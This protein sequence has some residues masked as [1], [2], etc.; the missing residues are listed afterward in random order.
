MKKIIN[1]LK[2]LLS[3]QSNP[4]NRII[5]IILTV[6]TLVFATL[7][8]LSYRSFYNQDGDLDK[9]VASQQ[10]INETESLLNTL[11]RTESNWVTYTYNPDKD[12]TV[13]QSINDK[14]DTI[15]ILSLSD[16]YQIANVNT[17]AQLVS[18]RWEKF[19]KPSAQ[20]R[21]PDSVYIDKV[22]RTVQQFKELETLKLQNYH[23]AA[24]QQ[25]RYSFYLN[26]GSVVIALMFGVLS[27][28]IFFRDREERKKV[29]SNLT[30]LN[31]NKD[32]FFSIIS[33]DLRG[34]TSNIVRLSEFLLEPN[35][36]ETDRKTMTLHLH[37][38][39]QNLQKLLENLLSWAKFQMGRL[40]FMPA[41]VDLYNLTNES[42]TQV[43][44]MAADKAI[45]IKNQ[46]PPRTYGFADD[47]MIMMVLRN[48]LVN[49]IK[50]TN[51][52]GTVK[53]S[54]SEADEYVSISV[55]D[56]GIGMPP[57]TTS[58]LFQLGNHFTTLGTS[59]EKGS[60]LGLIL[61]MELLEKNNGTIRVSSEQ[62]KGSTFTFTLPK[63]NK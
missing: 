52:S 55:S 31:L 48:L 10:V 44:T 47:Q 18:N 27:L 36:A 42:I 5:L 3:T 56:N 26:L 30:E 35:L 22:N 51:Q 29:E 20:V 49:A 50:F 24:V 14:I 32:K 61:C 17:L 38:A 2:E 28:F 60:G 11:L 4:K 13:Y 1:G 23:R 15:S 57:E 33:H 6:A 21:T 62:G 40:D 12:S 54:A 43:A 46:V 58:K 8:M 25:Q 59:N 9:I 37:K 39:A 63:L 7:I 45:L 41:P 53:I 19:A 34:P 16:P